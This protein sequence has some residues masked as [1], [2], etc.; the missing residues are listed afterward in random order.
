MDV[1]AHIG[2]PKTG[3]T[4]IQS[5]LRA[6]RASLAGRGVIYPTFS[7]GTDHQAELLAAVLHRIGK[8]GPDRYIRALP[9]LRGPQHY[10]RLAREVSQTLAQGT[11]DHPDGTMLLS[12]EMLGWPYLTPKFIKGFTGLMGE[13]FDGLRAILY[14]R[15]QDAWMLS[16]YSQHIKNGGTQTPKGWIN[17]LKV[18]NYD[19][20][21]ARWEKAV[22]A[23]NLTVRL[24]D[25]QRLKDGDLIA[26]F[27]EALGHDLPVA[28]SGKE[29]NT[30]LSARGARRIRKVNAIATRLGDA[31]AN[32]FPTKLVR[33]LLI[34][35]DRPSGGKITLID[36]QRARIRREAEPSN[37]ALCARRF[38]DL[39]TLFPTS[40]AA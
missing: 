15:A 2:M 32:R 16:G 4:S 22:G 35:T 29:E 38:P 28:P 33:R 10:D 20:L 24:L 5:A 21:V 14:L 39:D 12:C 36:A 1:I 7:R 18:P 3:T 25:R 13:H 19:K 26:D 31:R 23:E 40:N 8:A 34:D 17:G 37:V 27:A 9:E 6:N 11:R 30:T